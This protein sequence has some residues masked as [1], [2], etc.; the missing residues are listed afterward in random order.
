LLF[1]TAEFVIS[2]TLKYVLTEPIGV[3]LDSSLTFSEHITNLT[4][5]YYFQLRR[6]RAIHICLWVF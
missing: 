1:T 6:L 5:S 2:Y 4:R 3:I